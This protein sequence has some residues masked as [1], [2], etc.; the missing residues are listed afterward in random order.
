MSEPRGGK[1]KGRDQHHARAGL[2]RLNRANRK[3]AGREGDLTRLVGDDDALHDTVAYRRV[4]HTG[5]SLLAKFNRLAKASSDR[6]GEPGE[7]CGFDGGFVLVRDASGRETPCQVRRLLKKM[8]AGESSPLCIGDHVRTGAADDGSRVIEAV[9]PRTNQ[10]ERADSH[11]KALR[12]VFAAN[13]DRLVIVGS[14]ADPKLKTGLIDRYLVIAAAGGVMPIVALNKRDLADPLP[15]AA[16]YRDLGYAVVMTRGDHSG[17][18]GV[19][20]LRQLLTSTACVFAGQSGVGKSSLVA[21]LFPGLSVRVGA[22]SDALGKGRHTT[23]SAR[24]Y[25]LADGTR[26]IDTPGIRECALSGFT[27]VDVAL[28]FPEMAA[29]QPQCHYADCTHRH[30]PGCAVLAAVAAGTVHGERYA[31]YRAIV[32]EDLGGG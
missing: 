14:M 19:A 16:R 3:G 11:N 2:G 8:L 9:L 26:L 29:L 32:D 4:S 6:A 7:V 12:H 15:V 31:S 30:E 23:T 21:A 17:D 20:E 18:D 28:R 13:I 1:D 10:L 25:L 24:S 27:P 5:E 22:V